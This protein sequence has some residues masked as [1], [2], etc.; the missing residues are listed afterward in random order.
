MALQT[1]DSQHVS[2]VVSGRPSEGRV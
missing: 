2:R 1:T